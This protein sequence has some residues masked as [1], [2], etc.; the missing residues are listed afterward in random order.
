MGG[1]WGGGGG[2]VLGGRF[3]V[4][5]TGK[6]DRIVRLESLTYGSRIPTNPME[7]TLIRK[8]ITAHQYPELFHRHGDGPILTARDYLYPA[9]TVFNAGRGAISGR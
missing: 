9:H 1:V 7:M 6:P 8:P 2:G 5:Q 4:G 3:I